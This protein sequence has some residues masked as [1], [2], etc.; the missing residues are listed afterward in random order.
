[1]NP[2]APESEAGDLSPAE[3]Q[4][5]EWALRRQAP[6]ER[7][8]EAALQAWLRQSP[9]HGRLLAECEATS[10]QLDRLRRAA[11]P[12]GARRHLGLAAGIAALLAVS[13]AVHWSTRPDPLHYTATAAT[14]VGKFK[15]VTLPDGSLLTLNTDSAVEVAFAPDARRVRLLRGEAYFKVAHA[16]ER[17]FWVDAAQVRVK[18]VGTAFNVRYHP[19]K[20]EVT[21]TEGRVALDDAAGAA[22]AL[23]GRPGATG[24]APAAPETI[25]AGAR[26]TVALTATGAPA[27]LPVSVAA[28]P[29]PTAD[30]ALAWQSG[31]LEFSETP[32][33]EVVAEFN[34]YNRHR[35]VIEDPALATRTFG[36]AFACNG[37]ASFIEVLE[38]SFEVAAERRG[39]TTILRLR[40]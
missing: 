14:A 11:A 17:P 16:P 39:D 18:A 35:I 28:V 31:R 30:S 4:A 23:A 1:M 37:Y 27:D 13:A 25:T 20:V 8:D 36:G 9:D 33:A 15:R 10:A 40:R 34:R 7:G 32:L 3:L 38:R 6:L 2:P 26:A 29:V 22:L 24:A 12:G 21:V 19:Q 5:A